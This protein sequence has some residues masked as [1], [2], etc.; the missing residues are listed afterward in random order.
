MEK[1]KNSEVGWGE[2]RHQR[3]VGSE[4]ER[5]VGVLPVMRLGQKSQGWIKHIRPTGIKQT[6]KGKIGSYRI[7]V[8]RFDFYITVA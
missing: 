1:R 4:R 2:K 8:V 5:V 7:Y 3:C 6:F